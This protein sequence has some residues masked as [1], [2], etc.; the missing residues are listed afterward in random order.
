MLSFV[1]LLSYDYQ[2]VYDCI[3][4]YYDIADEII[5]GLDINRKTWRGQSFNIDMDAVNA[6]IA[7]IDVDKKI[8]IEESD[9]YKFRY[10]MN[11]DTFERNYLSTKC[12]EGNWIISIDADERVI[13]GKEFAEWMKQADKNTAIL[14]TWR[15]VFKSFGDKNILINA[16]ETTIVG[17]C[18]QNAYVSARDIDRPKVMSPLRLLH[19]SWGRNPDELWQKL[20]NW[21][22]SQDFDVKKFFD[23]WKSV[24]LD[25]YQQYKNIHPLNGVG[26]PSLILES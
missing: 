15:G 12:K 22:H 3:R 23:L 7:E 18:G 9:F 24:T 5:L 1:T 16:N 2:Y 10:S 17:V 21:S 26:W 4:S 25:N 20:N 11:N 13:N 19:F 6:F 8:R 14:A